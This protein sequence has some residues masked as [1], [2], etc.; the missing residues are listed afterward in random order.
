MASRRGY[1]GVNINTPLFETPMT[2]GAT[3]GCGAPGNL[4][5][6]CPDLTSFQTTEPEFITDFE[7]GVKSSWSIGDVQGRLNVAWFISEYEDAVQFL[8]TQALGIPNGTPDTPSSNSIGVNAADID[9]QGVEAELTV[10]PTPSLTLTL[11]AAYTDQSVVSINI[12]ASVLGLILTENDITLPTP[13]FSATF[14]FNWTLPFMPLDGE[15]IFNGDYYYTDD[16]GG[17][18]GESL[19]GYELTNFRLNWLGI[20][21]S[22]LDAA[23]FVKNAFDEEYISS[24]VVLLTSIPVSTVFAGEERTWGAELTYRF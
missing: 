22:G 18:Y 20:A 10:M 11:S 8:N 23:F 15:L 9:I 24:P 7:L 14:A 5:F 21:G 3:T 4:N 2:T 6:P 12:P 16:F 19:D 17:Q 13:E 1:R